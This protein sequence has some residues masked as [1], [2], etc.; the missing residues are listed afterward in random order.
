MSNQGST[1]VFVVDDE[2]I[3]AS[4]L[5]TILR[6]QGFSAEYFT[7]PVEALRSAG[8]HAPTLLISDVVMPG[9]S[10]IEL[11]MQFKSLCPGCR[12]LLF[13]GRAA[14]ADFLEGSTLLEQE[15]QVLQK[16]IHP[17]DLLAAIGAAGSAQQH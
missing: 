10:G 6:L 17:A 16:P 12:I 11:A 9:M 13:S 14:T 3:I 7:D 1:H 8:E 5:A 4:T 15:F 2:P